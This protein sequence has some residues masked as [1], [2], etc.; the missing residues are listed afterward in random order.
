MQ[1]E[2][3]GKRRTVKLLGIALDKKFCK[4]CSK[5]EQCIRK[6]GLAGVA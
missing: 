1:G 6:S 3:T 5:Q 4:R 2:G